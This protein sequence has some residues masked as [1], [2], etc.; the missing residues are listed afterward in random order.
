[1]SP[2]LSTYTA[3]DGS[4]IRFA[5]LVDFDND[6][7][8]ELVLIIDPP[9]LTSESPGD[10]H[11]LLLILTYTDN[12]EVIYRESLRTRGSEVEDFAVATSSGGQSH[13][14]SRTLDHGWSTM[15]YLTLSNGVWTS[16]LSVEFIMGEDTFDGFEDFDETG[17]FDEAGE[18]ENIVI[19]NE[20]FVNGEHV[21]EVVFM[22][23]E[24]EILGIVKTRALGIN[25]ENNVQALISRLGD[26][27]SFGNISI[28]SSLRQ[29]LHLQL[30]DV[31]EN[32]NDALAVLIQW[33][34]GRRTV[35]MRIAGSSEWVMEFRAGGTGEVL[36]TFTLGNDVISIALPATDRLYYLMED[37]TG[38]F[39]NPDGRNS[40]AF[41]WTYVIG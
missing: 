9:E 28:N 30:Y 31:I 2:V 26:D 20:Y 29:P 13:L 17:E 27:Y 7:V 6:G 18:E 40:E 14:V 41:T 23:A 37:F 11:F 33:Q 35:L 16:S 10:T 32:T 39:S 34:D 15:D 4:D 21:S 22:N 8:P 5:E 38:R 12:I 1:M 3:P 36:P 24:L 25:T 19:E